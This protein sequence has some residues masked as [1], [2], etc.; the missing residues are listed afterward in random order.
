MNVKGSQLPSADEIMALLP[1][2]KATPE[3]IA[4]VPAPHRLF[5]VSTACGTITGIRQ[6]GWVE[7]RGVPYATAQRFEQAVPV[8]AWEGVYDA[9]RWGDR[10]CQYNGFFPT[11]T[12]PVSKFYAAEAI[13]HRPA[14]YREDALELNIWA[15]EQAEG[16]PVLFY[17]HGGSFQT[18]SNTDVTTDGAVYARCGIVTV[19][20]NYR[21]SVFATAN[22]GGKYRGNLA[23]TDQIAALRWVYSH[24]ADFGGDPKRITLMGESAGAVSVQNLLVSPLVDRGMVHGAIMLSGGGHLFYNP[25]TEDVNRT[26]WKEFLDHMGVP[27]IEQLKEI[28]AKELYTQW[29]K[30]VG[31]RP[32][33]NLPCINE[34]SLTD[35]VAT[36]VERKTV[37]DVP[38]IIDVLSEDCFPLTLYQAARSYGEGRARTGGEPV[39]LSFFDRCQPG[40][41]TFGAFHAADLYYVFGSLHRGV[42]PYDDTD[43]RISAQMISY[44]AH[45]IHTGNPNRGELPPWD[46]CSAGEQ[47]FLH[48]GDAEPSMVF[49]DEEIFRYNSEHKPAFPYV[50][51]T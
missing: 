43:Y 39:Y 37:Q 18:G 2:E 15:P 31:T 13:A 26:C 33:S 36:H 9:T 25:T 8:A 51:D 29:M 6:D 34:L 50:K 30:S 44:F 38:V 24:I 21:L 14:G 28:P 46:P 12:N 11:L 7:F 41:T 19:S 42:R 5:T 32:G 4:D 10:C 1:R 40:D 16:C 49:P 47:P 20:I 48:I 45:F 17:I 27:F 3:Q 35:N 23:V 22:D